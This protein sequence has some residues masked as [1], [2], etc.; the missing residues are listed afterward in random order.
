MLVTFAHPD[1]GRGATGLFLADE[2]EA[3]YQAFMADLQAS[4]LVRGSTLYRLGLPAGG[5]TPSRY[6]SIHELDCDQDDLAGVHNA[7]LQHM[8]SGEADHQQAIEPGSPV[9][10][11]FWGYYNHIATHLKASEDELLARRGD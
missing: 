4:P 9:A 7:L 6:L 1:G 3:W 5:P 8:T 2:L 10:I 11:D